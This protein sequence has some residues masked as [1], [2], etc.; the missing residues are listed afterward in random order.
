MTKAKRAPRG[1]DKL[2]NRPKCFAR[3]SRA[4]G[5]EVIRSLI[6]WRLG[7]RARILRDGT[8]P[9]KCLI[10]ESRSDWEQWDRRRGQSD[11]KGFRD[12]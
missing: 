9:L 4:T 2:K 1:S 11:L 5:S 7:R 3:S 6:F 12:I 10:G 8:R